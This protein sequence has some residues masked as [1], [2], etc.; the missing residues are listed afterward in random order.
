MSNSHPL[1]ILIADQDPHAIFSLRA[2]LANLGHSVIAET[3]DGQEVIAL[4][5][6][7]R[8]DLIVINT[9]LGTVD[10]L[11][12]SKQI[13]Q[14]GLCPIILL[15]DC[16]ACLT[17]QQSVLSI[18]AHLV[19]PINEQDLGLAIE[20]A[21]DHFEQIR[22]LQLETV[23]LKAVLNIRSTIQ[24]ATEHLATHYRFS[25][26]EAHEW[27]QQEARAKKANLDQV[28][29]AVLNGNSVPYRYDVP[30]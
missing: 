7:L 5:W 17:K 30:I 8:P 4:A 22:L 19:K 26:R 27:V 23:R 16:Q 24:R 20:L 1:E 29:Q 21:I 13:D 15:S 2:Q 11:E 9:Q 14:G 10:G 12:A 25:P 3:S 28:A 6:D 18:Q